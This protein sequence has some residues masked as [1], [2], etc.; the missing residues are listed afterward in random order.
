MLTPK[1]DF[2][3]LCESIRP[4]PNAKA[5]ILGFYGVLPAATIR[6]ATLGTTAEQLVFVLGLRGPSDES[7]ARMNIY[8]PDDSILIGIPLPK[9]DPV[10]ADQAALFG[11]GVGGLQ[12]PAEGRYSLDIVINDTKVYRSTFDIQVGLMR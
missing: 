2:C 3:L 5:N 8:K 11:M 7:T 12:F 6:V 9:I 1:V 10:L 4:E